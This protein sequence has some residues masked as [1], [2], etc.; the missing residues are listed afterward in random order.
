MRP[1][2]GPEGE[3]ALATLV[4]A[5]PLLAFDFDGTLAPI[6]ARPQLARPARAVVRRLAALAPRLPVAVVSGRSVQDLQG[7]LG[8]VPRYL[9]G[10]HGAEGLPGAPPPAAAAAL[11][12]LRAR[13]AAA[14]P[15]LAAAGVTLE[16]KGATLSLHYRLARDRDAALRAVHQLLAPA[17][18]ALHVFGGKLV[19]NVVPREAPDKAAAMQAIARDCGAAAALFA[20]DDV[21]DEPVFATA[22]ESWL[23]VRVGC[24]A[25]H[26]RARWCMAGPADMPLLLERLLALLDGRPGAA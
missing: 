13:L 17:D 20:G 18:A 19:V 15:S 10:N 23:T 3:A 6:V 4:R 9:V 25:T 12:A 2:F 21:N 26:S 22:P 16:D 1:L 8:F 14:R 5:R 24:D 7:R 11:D